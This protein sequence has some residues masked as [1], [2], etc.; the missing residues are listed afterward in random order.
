MFDDVINNTPLT[1]CLGRLLFWLCCCCYIVD[2]TAAILH[3]VCR[4]LEGFVDLRTH[5][6][7]LKKESTSSFFQ[8]R[9]DLYRLTC[10]YVHLSDMRVSF[11]SS[12]EQL[13]ESYAHP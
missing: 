11:Y 10:P 7:F 12:S 2:E 8:M 3:D 1:L 9:S 5:D 13:F 6:D 4:I